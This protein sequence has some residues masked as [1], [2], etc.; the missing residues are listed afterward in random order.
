M[1]TYLLNIEQGI[2]PLKGAV[3]SENAAQIKAEL[4]NLRTRLDDFQT[5]FKARIKRITG[6][7]V[8]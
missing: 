2:L 3:D 1:I 7:E 4:G 6:T 5:T 8:M